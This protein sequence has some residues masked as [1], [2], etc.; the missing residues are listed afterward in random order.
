MNRLLIV[1][2]GLTEVNFVTQILKPHLEDRASGQLNVS[3]PN[4]MGFKKYAAIKKFVRKL[5]ASPDTGAVVTT[6]VDL[7][8]IPGDFPGLAN[9]SR[10]SPADRVRHLEECFNADVA[11]GR[12]FAYLQLHEFEA[13]L[14]A[15]SSAL[16]ELHPNRQAGIQALE[17]RVARFNSPELVNRDRPPSYWIKDAIPEYH[18]TV[19]G[20]IVTGT[21]GLSR[22]RERCP[23]FGEWLSRLEDLTPRPIHSPY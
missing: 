1:A 8:R 7:F 22:L 9:A 10:K 11:D 12:F 13:L 15:D 14:L 2:E 16:I 19:D 4:L 5:L 3:A 20:P 6:M 17:K 18:K 21:I 23:H